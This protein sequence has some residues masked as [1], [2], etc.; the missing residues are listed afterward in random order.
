M[1]FASPLALA[2]LVPWAILT[3]WLLWARHRA[4]SVPVIVLWRGAVKLPRAS[5]QFSPPPLSLVAILSAILLAILAAAAP[6]IPRGKSPPPVTLILDRGITM[7]ARGRIDEVLS[8][9]KDLKP[10]RRITVPD[11]PAASHQPTTI[12]DDSAELQRTVANLPIRP[13]PS[14]CSLTNPCA[15]IR[16]SSCS[17]RPSP[18]PTSPSPISRSAHIRPR[19]R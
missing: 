10:S 13:I 9:V 3:L 11:D 18:S 5:R 17:P 6:A 2:L 4:T 7:S 16:A 12:D 1:T 14:S 8:L 19:R 15:T